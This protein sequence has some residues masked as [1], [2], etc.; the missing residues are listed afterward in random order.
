MAKEVT[1]EQAERKK[2]QAAAFMERLGQSDRADEFG[3]MSV[4]DYAEHKG[5]R[6]ANPKTRRRASMTNGMTTTKTDLQ[7][8]IDE[9]IDVLDD[10]Y[11]PESTREDLAEA[12]GHA[13]DV[14][15]GEEEEDEEDAD[16]AGDE[17]FQD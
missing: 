1:R 8:Q 17:D 15:R 14:L 3:D 9:A 4:D 7:G 12:I 11:Q 5:L 2:A 10:A 16:D 6:L 13:L